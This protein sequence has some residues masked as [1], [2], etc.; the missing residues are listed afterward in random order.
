MSLVLS[1]VSATQLCAGCAV[2]FEA[3]DTLGATDDAA[4]VGMTADVLRMGDQGFLVSSDALGGV[5]IVYD[6]DGRYQGP[7]TREGGGPG[8]LVGPP[9]F[10]MGPGGILL[11]ERFSPSLH[12]FSEDLEFTRTIRINGSAGSIQPDPVTAG[13]LVSYNRGGGGSEAGIMLLDRN[14][15]LILSMQPGEASSSLS[16]I[17]GDVIRGGD[18]MIWVASVVGMVELFDE[19][20]GLQGSL[21]LQLPGMDAWDPATGPAAPPA[22]V[23]DMRLA[24][25]G[26]GV[27]VFAI[28]PAASVTDLRGL[29]GP[30]DMEELFDTFVYWIGVGTNGL[31]LVGAD[32]FDNL[33]RPLG[34]GGMAFDLVDMPDGDRRVRVGR[35]RLT[36]GSR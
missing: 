12:L 27:W 17:T 36:T 6:T 11:H 30:P 7:L 8:E 9:Q 34:S 21:Q 28:G 22:M 18:G 4:G 20:M 24:P 23:T 26:S 13:W 2:E 1:L 3:L 15:D 10:A 14:G 25:D 16:Y 33:V 35:L 19:D 31:T 5:V 32:R 29:T